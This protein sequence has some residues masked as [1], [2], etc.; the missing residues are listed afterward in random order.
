MYNHNN[1]N[2]ECSNLTVVCHTT[3]RIS[4]LLTACHREDQR[5]STLVTRGEVDGVLCLQTDA[6]EV[7]HSKTIH[8]AIAEGLPIVAVGLASAQQLLQMG[9][10]VIG[11]YDLSLAPLAS[12]AA[13]VFP[14]VT[15]SSA[16]TTTRSSSKRQADS[17]RQV[18]SASYS[19]FLPAEQ[20]CDESLGYYVASSF[21]AHWQEE[22]TYTNHVTPKY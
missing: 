15:P 17:R 20:V 10:L 16:A 7:L 14:F 22:K 8:A 6:E 18:M 1:A 12:S 4:S 5:L 19:Y 11:C 3:S 2:H 21:A 13:T 9:G